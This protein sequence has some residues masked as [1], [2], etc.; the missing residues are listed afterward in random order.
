MHDVEVLGRLTSLTALD[1]QRQYSETAG[2]GSAHP[3]AALAALRAALPRCEA[4]I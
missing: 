4:L 1:L 2:P 3:P